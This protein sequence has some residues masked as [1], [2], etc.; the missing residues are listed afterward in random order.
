MYR[1]VYSTFLILLPSLLNIFSISVSVDFNLIRN[2]RLHVHHR[3]VFLKIGLL[4]VILFL[5][6]VQSGGRVAFQGLSY[7]SSL[8]FRPEDYCWQLSRVN[9]KE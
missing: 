1:H 4:F 8:D 3:I 6:C 2:S 9:L 5:E 7:L